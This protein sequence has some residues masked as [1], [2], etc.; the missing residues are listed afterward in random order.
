MKRRTIS[1]VLFRLAVVGCVNEERMMSDELSREFPYSTVP[2]LP[3]PPMPTPPTSP[4]YPSVLPT[5]AFSSIKYNG[6]TVME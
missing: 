6:M 2:P 4:T 3:P 1:F 5:L